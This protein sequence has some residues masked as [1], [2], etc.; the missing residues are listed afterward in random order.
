MHS[1]GHPGRDRSV[2]LLLRRYYWPVARRD[3]ARFFQYCRVCQVFKGAATNAG[4]YLPFPVP[5]HPW[6][7]LSMD[8]VL[9]LARTQWGND[10]NFVVVDGFS[11]MV[12]FVPCKRAADVVHVATLFFR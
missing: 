8:F 6:T 10:S 4:L 5:S 7:A 3:M 12:H 9:G 1:A 11:K 2:E